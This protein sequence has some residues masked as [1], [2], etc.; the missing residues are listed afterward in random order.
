[1]KKLAQIF[2]I[3]KLGS[4]VAPKQ[5]HMLNVI[6]NNIHTSS[7]KPIVRAACKDESKS[8]IVRQIRMGPM[9]HVVIWHASGLPYNRFTRPVILLFIELF[10]III[11]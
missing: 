3:F 5:F 8:C 10:I 4:K 2:M 1:M 7:I 9:G 11:K 6:R